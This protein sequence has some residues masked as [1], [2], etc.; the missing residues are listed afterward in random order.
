MP[1]KVTL[2]GGSIALVILLFVARFAVHIRQPEPLSRAEVVRVES[3]TCAGELPN[4]VGTGFVWRSATEVVTALHVVAGCETAVVYSE[5]EKMTYAATVSRV[6]E[7]ADLALLRIDSD[8]SLPFLPMLATRPK[9]GD[10]LIAWGYPEAIPAMRSHFMRVVEGGRTLRENVPSRAAADIRRAG[11]PSLD[12]EVVPIQE[13]M[14]PGISGAPI[15]DRA[16]RVRA[17][18]DGGV[19]HGITDVSWATPAD[20]INELAVSTELTSSYV[21]PNAHLSAAEVSRAEYYSADFVAP[22]APKT[23]CGPTALTKVR[24]TLFSK[25]ESV[26]DRASALQRWLADIDRGAK[27]PLVLDKADVWT[28][29]ESGATLA[30]P[31]G[32]QITEEEQFCRAGHVVFQIKPVTSGWPN[33]SVVMEFENLV[34]APTTSDRN[35]ALITDEGFFREDGLIA[36]YRSYER[37]KQGERRSGSLTESLMIKNGTL[38][39][40]AFWRAWDCRQPSPGV[41]CQP[42]PDISSIPS[43][44]AVEFATFAVTASRPPNPRLQR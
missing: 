34:A 42:P 29:V 37:R 26:T 27:T 2:H 30:I 13:A 9:M 35:W 4:R 20:Y 40:I 8:A 24:Q 43:E 17:I 38:L 6:L 33:D 28:D 10:E 12:M 1:R 25:V 7:R 16:G 3:H 39:A 44:L 5:R 14:P 31:A 41:V 11:S 21:A 22:N 15:L 19:D 32:Q 36:V 23:H 18:A